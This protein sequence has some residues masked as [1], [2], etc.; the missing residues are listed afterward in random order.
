MLFV[1]PQAVPRFIIPGCDFSFSPHGKTAILR[2]GGEADVRAVTKRRSELDL[3]VSG[4]FAFAP[5]ELGSSGAAL[6][7]DLEPTQ[8]HAGS[9]CN[10]AE[11]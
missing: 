4:I 5:I 1:R 3:S 10:P 2:G 6:N 8:L 9:Q 7:Q 11:I